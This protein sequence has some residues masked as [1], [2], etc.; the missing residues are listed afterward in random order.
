M[1]ASKD[2]RRKVSSEA[3]WDKVKPNLFC[4]KAAFEHEDKTA[5]GNNKVIRAEETCMLFFVVHG[6]ID[7]L[8]S[9]WQR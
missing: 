4:Q 3:Y 5:E 2:K 6:S 8:L 1:Q 7:Q 9:Y